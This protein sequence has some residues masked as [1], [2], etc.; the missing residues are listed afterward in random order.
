VAIGKQGGQEMFDDLILTDDD[1]S[2]FAQDVF[3]RLVETFYGLK[4]FWF[5]GCRRLRHE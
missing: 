3:P 2:H 5:G 1:L 4:I